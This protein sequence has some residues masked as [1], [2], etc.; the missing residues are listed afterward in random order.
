LPYFVL[1][2]MQGQLYIAIFCVK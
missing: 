1:N 2:K